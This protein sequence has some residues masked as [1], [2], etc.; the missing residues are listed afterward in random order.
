MH[1][2]RTPAE[3]DKLRDKWLEPPDDEERDLTEQEQREIAA[4][5]KWEEQRGQ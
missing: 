5:L 4:E 1:Y 2:A 3:I